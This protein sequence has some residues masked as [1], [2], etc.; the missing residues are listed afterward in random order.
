MNAAKRRLAYLGIA[1]CTGTAVFAA[2]PSFSWTAPDN[3]AGKC[4][5]Y[6]NSSGHSVPRPCGNWHSDQAR[7]VDHRVVAERGNISADRTAQTLRF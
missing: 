6:A 7:D 5:Y 4:G 3:F 1:V 2:D